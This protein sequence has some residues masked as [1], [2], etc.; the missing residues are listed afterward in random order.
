MMTDKPVQ[1]MGAAAAYVH[2]T[3][4]MDQSSVGVGLR[5]DVNPRAALKLQWERFHMH[6]SGGTIWGLSDTSPSRASVLSMAMDFIF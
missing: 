3:S 4:R 2:Q 1:M 5:W 6:E